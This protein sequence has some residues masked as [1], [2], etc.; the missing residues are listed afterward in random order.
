MVYVPD[1]G[2]VPLTAALSRI[3]RDVE[4]VIDA[5]LPSERAEGP[6]RVLF[7]SMRYACLSGGKRLRPFLVA[8]SGSLFGVKESSSLRVG[9]A[10]ELIHNYS[11]IH[12][13]LPC[14]D[15]D[16]LRR[17]RPA[18]HVRFGEAIAVLTG[19]ALM[20]LAFEILSDPRTDP[21]AE[22][23]TRLV[24]LLARAA[25]PL[26]MVGGQVIDLEAESMTLD[27]SEIIRLERLKTGA[28]IGFCCEAGAVLGRATPDCER[29]LQAYAHDLGLAYQIADDLIDVEGDIA[30]TG[31]ATGKDA[32]RGKATFVSILG[33]DQARSQA[34]A[35]AAQAVGHVT[36]F[37]ARAQPLIDL[38]AFVVARRS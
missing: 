1:A 21:D 32:A 28:L 25:G 30:I 11:L 29:A 36:R 2:P 14:M 24:T 13:D 15:D 35:L 26:G 34:E 23:R 33:I 27:P 6:E 18:C 7:E 38:A 4:A 8:A 22:I 10:V 20:P 5:I 19:D 9:A 3:A 31:K 16:S 17:G 37:G 12:D